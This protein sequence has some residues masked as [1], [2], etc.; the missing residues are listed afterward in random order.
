MISPDAEP[1]ESLGPLEPPYPSP[2]YKRNYTLAL[3]QVC[4]KKFLKIFFKQR[5]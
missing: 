5:L 3:T 2:A 4:S 1:E